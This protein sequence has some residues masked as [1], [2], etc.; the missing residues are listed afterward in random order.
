MFALVDYDNIKLIRKEHTD[1]DVE[2][3]VVEIA[4]AAASSI[5][6]VQPGLSE[7]DIRFYGG[8]NTQN[9]VPTELG[10]RMMRCHQSAR[11]RFFGVTVRP[12][13]ATAPIA[14]PHAALWGFLN[15]RLKERRQKMVDTL[16]AVDAM[17]LM[18]DTDTYVLSDDQDMVPVLLTGHLKTGRVASL[19]GRPSGS[20]PFDVILDLHGVPLLT[21]PEEFRRG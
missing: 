18:A 1:E 10:Q 8:W 3:N 15:T 9:R 14:Y 7:L 13:I 20:Y 6:A 16:L 4:R 17:T 11:S 5:R 2:Y 21:L 12:S 19:R